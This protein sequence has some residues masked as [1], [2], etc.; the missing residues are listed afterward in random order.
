RLGTISM[1]VF[2][3]GERSSG[4]DAPVTRGLTRAQI[5]KEGVA[6]KSIE[7]LK[8]TLYASADQGKQSRMLTRGLIADDGKVQDGSRLVEEDFKNPTEVQ[9]LLIRYYQRKQ[10]Q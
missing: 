9:H 1:H 6:V 7:D 8:R 3:E 4:G 10:P 5:E 2:V